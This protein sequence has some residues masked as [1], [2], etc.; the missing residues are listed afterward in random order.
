MTEEFHY[1]RDSKY[2]KLATNILDKREKIMIGY[3]QLEEIY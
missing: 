3:Y 1:L 2:G